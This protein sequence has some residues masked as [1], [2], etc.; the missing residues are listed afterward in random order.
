MGYRTSPPLVVVHGYDPCRCRHL[1][2]S[3]AYK[4]QPLTK[5][6]NQYWSGDRG[7]IPVIQ[8]GKLARNPSRTLR[9]W[10]TVWD[11]NPTDRSCKDQLRSR[12]RPI[13]FSAITWPSGPSGARAGTSTGLS[14]SALC[15]IVQTPCR[16]ASEF[17][18][19]CGG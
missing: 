3:R 10:W 9:I 2:L 4:A 17:P 1:L 11:S 13:V 18:S 6:D 8:L 16:I 7:T 5:A 19:N 15:Q 14:G 12:A